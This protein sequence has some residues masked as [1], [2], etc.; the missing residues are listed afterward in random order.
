[1]TT[2]QVTSGLGSRT[3]TAIGLA[4]TLAACGGGGGGGGGTSRPLPTP[5]PTPSPAPAPAP[6]P[7][8]TPTPTISAAEYANSQA[9]SQANAVVAYEQGIDGEG[10]K[11]A[12]VDSGISAGLVDF[13]GRIDPASDDVAGERGVS[14]DDGHGTAVTAIAAAAA[15]GIDML[16]VAHGAT[17]LSY[18]ADDP[19][20]C[21]NEEGCDFY[22]SDIA[23]AVDAA[24]EA[25]A[26]VINLSLG[27]EGAGAG[28]LAAI[29]RA[30]DA[31]IVVVVAAGN[32]GEAL[33]N[34][35]AQDLVESTVG[36]NVIIA[37]SVGTF[38][39]PGEI[40]DFSN[41]A[42]NEMQLQDFFLTARGF[43]VRAPD[44]TGTQFLWSGTSFSA[45]A[46][47]GAVALL[48]QAFP[49]LTGSEIVEILLASASDRGITGPDDI[50]GQGELNI[51][52][53]L[54]PSGTTSIAGSQIAISMV[55][56]GALPAAAGDAAQGSMQTI[57]TDAYDRAYRLDLH[58][59]LQR[60][61]S[62][63]P[64]HRSLAGTGLRHR[65]LDM[66]AISLSLSMD[67][68]ERRLDVNG[69][70]DQMGADERERS[71]L[72]AGSVIAA[73]DKETKAALGFSESAYRMAS[74]M[75]EI[76]TGAFL[77]AREG[78]GDV[79]FA[80]SPG[81]SMAVRR[82]LG[83]VA[84]TLSSE[85]GAHFSR[86]ANDGYEARYRLDSVA[87]DR[88]TVA[89]GRIRLGLSMLDE[90]ET[91]LGGRLSPALGDDGNGA[92]T[93]F[94]DLTLSQPLGD[95]FALG[96]SARRGDTVFGGGRFATGSYALDLTRR[97]LF[98]DGDRL[99]VRVSQPL[100]IEQGGLDL[101]LPQ[102]W[103]WR[104][105]SATMGMQRLSL[106]PSGRELVGEVAYGRPWLGGRLDLN[107]Y[108]RRQPGHVAAADGDIGA[109]IRFSLGL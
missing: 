43:Q 62:R 48:A 78:L 108:Y 54:A 64:L 76:D 74:R 87:L 2:K 94:V 41:R 59:T 61:A 22:D 58:R 93:R 55:D 72:V 16:G 28:L 68:R 35:F 104:T 19:G 3:M 73:L 46:I 39:N 56:N 34:Q 97:H 9:A 86:L 13:A 17:I 7:T 8:P 101:L 31:G 25:G 90:R 84:L 38:A 47:S 99:G 105:E 32:E 18:R 66:G 91:L 75:A 27:G 11:I 83:P 42:G 79:G 26:R 57:V 69:L 107:A 88:P 81:Q 70:F 49:N 21:A 40:S 98:E 44:H 50:Y 92:Q 60:A 24:R 89:G 52:A 23:I 109:A 51:A 20:S 10:V 30:A 33:P 12:I 14:D 96:L 82:D 80:A 65:S 67:D 53:A 106:A 103:D 95:H 1:M 45:P 63:E 29:Q 6:T 71:K 15:D 4:L 85:S 5:T 36:G 100:R 77:V 102:S 37:G